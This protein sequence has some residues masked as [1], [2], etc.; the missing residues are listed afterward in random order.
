M[1]FYTFGPLLVIDDS[2]LEPVINIT[3]SAQDA[4]TL[5]SVT[6]YDMGGT[7][8]PLTTNSKGYVGQFQ[9][10]DTSSRL[11]VTFGTMQLEIIPHEATAGDVAGAVD[12]WMAANLASLQGEDLAVSTLLA[13]RTSASG[14]AARDAA[15]VLNVK[16]YGA[17]GDGVTDDTSAIQAAIEAAAASTRTKTVTVPAGRYVVSRIF[18]RIGVT[19]EGVGGAVLEQKAAGS[20]STVQIPDGATGATVRN[21]EIDG[22]S[23]SQT[24]LVNGIDIS[25]DRATLE[26]CYIHDTSG[27]GVAATA[28]AF[29]VT[30]RGNRVERAGGSG[31]GISGANH[32]VVSSNH[33][34]NTGGAGVG[35]A[36]SAREVAVVVNTIRDCT[37]DGVVG[38]E[39]TLKNIT[40]TGNIVNT[41]GN[42][43]LHLGGQGIVMADNV[44]Y[45]VQVGHG[46]FVRNHD[47]T[48]AHDVS[49]TG[50]AV[51]TS[52]Q[53]AVRVDIADGV[54]ISGNS[55]NGT[56]TAI[57]ALLSANVAIDGNMMRNSSISGCRV[58]QSSA[59]TVAGNVFESSGADAIYLTGSSLVSVSGNTVDGTTAGRG[60]RLIRTQKVSVAGNVLQS[61]AT[62]GIFGGDGAT[63]ASATVLVTVT[64]NTI[65]GT[66]ATG[67]ST[68]ESSDRWLVDSNIVQNTTGTAVS[69]VGSNNSIGTNL[70]S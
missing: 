1:G 9:A 55:G 16:D 50:N 24:G 36:A 23:A 8:A 26:G 52:A 70:T 34:E 11:R 54:T 53:S 57:Y 30:I 58:D 56:T 5:A 61:I 33:I 51:W 18:V 69:L 43:G 21:L 14:I 20:F 2:T 32:V 10:P 45:N 39:S 19:L 41:P 46:L 68:I 44:I 63:P 37:L 13:D 31:I 35:I 60:I 49:I 22:E 48:T 3:G 65:D 29:W 62:D 47:D 6:T 64:G 27:K 12:N 40:A 17:V 25:A 15:A 4:D 7:V 28:P 66:G 42:H 38:Y 67:I 59:V